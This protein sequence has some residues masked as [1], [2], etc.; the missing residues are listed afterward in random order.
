METSNILFYI[1][2]IVDIAYT[3]YICLHVYFNL[4]GGCLAGLD[5]QSGREE[6]RK[7]NLQQLGMYVLMLVITIIGFCL[8]GSTRMYFK[9]GQ[10][11]VCCAL[12]VIL[13]LFYLDKDDKFDSR[14]IPFHFL[15]IASLGLQIVCFIYGV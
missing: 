2:L 5:H 11:I 1:N 4:M 3:L 13:A 8:G 12:F 9:L 7:K 6:R 14:F 15:Y 10:K